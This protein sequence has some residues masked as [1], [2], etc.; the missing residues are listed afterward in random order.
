MLYG[1]EDTPADFEDEPDPDPG[2]VTDSGDEPDPE[3]ERELELGGELE[4]ELE[5]E[6]DLGPELEL[7]GEPDPELELGEDPNLELELELG[8]E[9]D[10]ELE[11]ELG[12][13]PDLEL[14]PELGPELELG[15]EPNLELELELELGEEPDLEKV[16]EW[17][18]LETAQLAEIEG[19]VADQ[20]LEDEEGEEGGTVQ[21]HWDQAESDEDIEG[22]ALR[23]AEDGRL[24]EIQ[25]LLLD[26]RRFLITFNKPMSYTCIEDEGIS[27]DDLKDIQG[28]AY[29]LKHSHSQEAL[30]DLARLN[31]LCSP[32]MMEKKLQH[33][34]GLEE[35]C[36]NC[37]INSC[38]LFTG[39]LLIWMPVI[40]ALNP[41]KTTEES[42][43]I[44]FTI[45]PLYHAYK[46]SSNLTISLKCFNIA[47][48]WDH[49]GEHCVMS[50]M[51]STSGPY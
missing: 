8:S 29:N 26:S 1:D 48:S 15:E 33:F 17:F 34:S 31:G 50:L 40:S 51:V 38:M 39:P 47:R 11:L 37:C 35:E 12:G 45:S 10:P 22:D 28:L 4:L 44:F 2:P 16:A 42:H 18:Q 7:G 41:V 30:E 32:Y 36:Y 5:D 21:L 49:I 25:S 27:N 24:E 20:E 43:E 9:P 46:P 14:R 23:A 13:E 6:P 3:L 19:A